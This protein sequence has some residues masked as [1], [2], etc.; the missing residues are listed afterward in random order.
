MA[1]AKTVW[2]SPCPSVALSRTI[3]VQLINAH[4]RWNITLAILIVFSRDRNTDRETEELIIKLIVHVWLLD[5]HQHRLNRWFGCL[6][7]LSGALRVKSLV[8]RDRA[9]DW[10]HLFGSGQAELSDPKPGMS[11][12]VGYIRCLRL[13]FAT[14]S[15]VERFPNECRP[16]FTASMTQTF[17][18]YQ[19]VNQASGIHDNNINKHSCLIDVIILYSSII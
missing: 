10:T 16:E 11:E 13:L 17:L 1:C 12:A 15:V 7:R 5:H 9:L 2:S 19:C 18:S 3:F 4:R 14:F 6:C 8:I